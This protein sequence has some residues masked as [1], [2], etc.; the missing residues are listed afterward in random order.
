ALLI[1]ATRKWP[2]PP[3]SLPAREYMERARQRWDALGLGPLQLAEPWY[4]Y[5]LGAWPPEVQEEAALAVQGRYAEVGERA[6]AT[7]QKL[8][9]VAAERRPG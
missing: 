6:R 7:R 3:L 1:D 8:E 5:P 9:P 2:Y 4:G